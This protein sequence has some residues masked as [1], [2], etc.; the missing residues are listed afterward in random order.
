MP[1]SWNANDQMQKIRCI[2][3]IAEEQGISFTY[4]RPLERIAIC[5]QFSLVARCP[6]VLVTF[7]LAPASQLFF[8]LHMRHFEPHQWRRG[9]PV[10]PPLYPLY[11]RTLEP[12]SRGIS[13]PPTNCTSNQ[14]HHLM[15]PQS[16]INCCHPYHPYLTF[17]SPRN[18]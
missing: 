10:C 1:C 2:F 7:S 15:N 16:S 3:L 13:P 11:P 8:W 17:L 12:G 18:T 14:L 6:G 9:L 5:M 4:I